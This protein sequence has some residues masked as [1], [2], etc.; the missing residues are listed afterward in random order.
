M[1][2][3]KPTPKRLERPL[4][5][6]EDDWSEAVRREAAVR[7]LATADIKSRPVL[8]AAA[9]DLGIST[10]QLYRLIAQYRQHPVTGSLVITKPGPRKGTRLLSGDVEQRIEDAIDRIFKTRECPSVEKL[11][12][13]IRADCRAAGLQPPSRKAIQARLSAR[14]LRELVTARKGAE[15]ARQAFAPV[16]PG[17]RPSC[18]LEI[19]QIDHTKVDIQLVDDLSRAVVGRPWLTVVLDV[20]SRSVMGF[21]LS[22]DAP[23]AS[24]VALAISQAVLAKSDWLS[25]RGL[26][27]A[28]PMQ[29]VPHAIHLDNGKEFHSKALKR[30]CQQHGMCI[31]YRPPATPRFGGH[32]ERLMGTLM[33]RVHALPG[34][35]F[36]NVVARGDYSAERKAILT[37][38]EFERILALEIL[39]PYHNEVHA[40]LGTTPAAA[41]AAGVAAREIGLPRDPAA[42]VLDFL[43]FKE[44]VIRRE[45]VRLFN[46]SYFDGALASLLDSPAR[47]CR[48]K[49]DPRN[50][51]A[52][53]VERPTGS[54][55]RV[56]CADLSRPAVTLWEQQTAIQALRAE[57]RASVNEATIFAAIEAQRRVLA[58]AQVSSKAARRATAR[59]PDRRSPATEAEPP[60]T[61]ETT[62]HVAAGEDEA[63]VPCVVEDE[64][65][66]TE[67]LP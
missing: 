12:R 25:E 8:D 49:Y 4:D 38:R 65:W 14:S 11:R 45:G 10:S 39:G 44:R 43:P 33:T 32:I 54:H 26:D 9:A 28:W 31:D 52:V 15:A 21:Y 51:S 60:A 66:Q 55:L 22:F 56:P 61:P 1:A 34:T 2:A 30:G 24:G 6:P 16:R 47:T 3:T 35:T 59:L 40:A 36:S 37:L 20:F 58:E 41:W 67:F 50:M 48:I 42:F 18:P 19:V 64:A 63:R 13:E 5:V 7:P 57:G 17:L 53:F 27:F 29:G 62:P 46:V 23:S